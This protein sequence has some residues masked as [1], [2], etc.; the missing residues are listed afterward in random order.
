MLEPILVILFIAVLL[1][2]IAALLG[3]GKAIGMIVE[4]KLCGHQWKVIEDACVKVYNPGENEYT[5][6]PV[7]IT[8]VLTCT[9]CGKIMKVRS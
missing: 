7:E 4:Y 6:Y 9:K 3:L 8:T 5:A 2:T 1:Y